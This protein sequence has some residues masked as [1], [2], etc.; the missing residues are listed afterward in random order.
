MFDLFL[1]ACVSWNLLI[2]HLKLSKKLFCNTNQNGAF[3]TKYLCTF[4]II[5]L[6][7]LFASHIV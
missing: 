1:F 2:L 6:Y 4:A 7:C 3:Y 5:S